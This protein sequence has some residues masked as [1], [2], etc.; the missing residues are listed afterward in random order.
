MTW[1]YG[2]HQRPNNF[3]KA[4]AHLQRHRFVILSGGKISRCEYT[5]VAWVEELAYGHIKHQSRI[6]RDT[7]V[8]ITPPTET[9]AHASSANGLATPETTIFG[10]KRSMN[11][12][13]S[14][15]VPQRSTSNPPGLCVG[16]AFRAMANVR[17][18]TSRHD[19]TD[20]ISTVKK[21]RQITLFITRG[22]SALQ[23]CL[24]CH[25]SCSLPV[26]SGTARLTRISGPFITRIHSRSKN[27]LKMSLASSL[28]I[29]AS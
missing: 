25:C 4:Q 11:R 14:C 24:S 17:P 16:S 26:P 5:P 18:R 29:T 1:L 3:T 15:S 13:S 28:G 6:Q 22:Q 20:A 27:W 9:L 19:S 21:C 7:T 23:W 12:L 10:R 8:M 2:V